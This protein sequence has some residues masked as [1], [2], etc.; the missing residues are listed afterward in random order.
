MI[1]PGSRFRRA[2]DLER[3]RKGLAAAPTNMR[4]APMASP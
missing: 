4:Q 3:V 1:P 2:P